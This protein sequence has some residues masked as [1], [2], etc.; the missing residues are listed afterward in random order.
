QV[1]L[2]FIAIL[3][4]AAVFGGLRLLYTADQPIYV[5]ALTLIL[6]SIALGVSIGFFY[7]Y[8]VK[9]PMWLA[10]E[11]DL[12]ARFPDQPWMLNPDWAKRKLIH[13]E[14]GSVVFLWIVVAGW[15]GVLGLIG[16]ARYRQ[17]LLAFSQS[18]WNAGFAALF[19]AAGFAA[20]ALA[21]MITRNW[22]RFGRSELTIETL[23]GHLGQTFHGL[24][25]AKLPP[26]TN[27]LTVE[28]ICEA[29][30][31]VTTRGGDG[32][33]RR[34]VITELG[35]VHRII[36]VESRQRRNIRSVVPISI[37]L[38]ADLPECQEEDG[39]NQNIRWRLEVSCSDRQSRQPHCAFEIPV[40]RQR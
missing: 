13:S 28:L 32:Q 35:R 12:K 30:C 38:P 14:I 23:P 5:A 20:F 16:T 25:N 31:W 37:D 1:F 36:P 40:F 17:I 29:S 22:L 6:G 8:Y 11:A 2:A 21:L 19:V 10:R 15:W 18:W 24:L 39:N 26:E 34:R 4:L 33:V 27:D 9:A 7:I 3:G